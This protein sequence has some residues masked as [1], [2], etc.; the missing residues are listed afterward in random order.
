M[1][2]IKRILAPTDFSEASFA[3]VHYALE[4]AKIAG[5][6]LHLLHVIE[7]PIYYSPAFGGFTPNRE[8]LD[9]YADA[10]LESV[11]LADEPTTVPVI[12]R[13]VEGAAGSSIAEYAEENNIDMIVIGT[14][15]RNAA[16]RFF[17]GSVA[18]RVVRKAPC[19]VVTVPPGTATLSEDE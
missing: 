13:H 19:P 12:R 8:E 18:E 2:Q 16:Q 17:V 1:F 15:G 7:L 14:H 3:A 10:G 9:A 6:E 11:T 5:A 4:L